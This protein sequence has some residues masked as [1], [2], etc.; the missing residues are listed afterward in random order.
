MFIA[1]VTL[2]LLLMNGS[3]TKQSYYGDCRLKDIENIIGGD[4]YTIDSIV[5]RSIVTECTKTGGN[6]DDAK[7]EIW[8]AGRMTNI[9]SQESKGFV[10]IFSPNDCAS[11]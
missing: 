7:D 10:Y 9:A 6:G 1:F 8:V 2:V 11:T 5:V 4:T 3:L